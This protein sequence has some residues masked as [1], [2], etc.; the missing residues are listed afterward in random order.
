[1]RATLGYDRIANG[2]V[3][4]SASRVVLAGR[5]GAGKGTQG[6]RLARRLGVQHLSTGDV[7]R[8]EIATQSPLG[9]AVERLVSAGRLVP[10]EMILTVIEAKLDGCGYVLDGFPRTVA[11]AEVLFRIPALAPMAAIDIVVSGR[12]ALDRL[13]ARGRR[14]DDSAVAL[15]RLA[16]YDA[17]TAP[18]LEW[19]DRRGI[20]VSVDGHDSPDAVERNVWRVLQCFSRGHDGRRF[21]KAGGSETLATPRTVRGLGPSR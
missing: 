12:V 17:E 21:P 19:L 6:R 15:D 1:M 5:P 3:E 10:T 11:Q 16:T 20:L 14:D 2:S 18:A 13:L 8:D 9:C 4:A 7:L